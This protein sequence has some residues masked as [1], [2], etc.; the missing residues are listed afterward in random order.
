MTISRLTLPLLA[1]L[2]LALAACGINSVPRAEE[3]ARAKWAD[4]EAAYQRR[5]NLIP[6]LVE[7]VRGFAD[8]EREVLIGVA[9][10]RARASRVEISAED[11][12]D[13]EA[14]RQ[15][16]EAQGALGS[17]LG[18]L[19]VT[20][21]AYPELRSSELFANLQS[22]LEGTEN[23]IAIAI[24]DYNEAVRDYNT[25]LRT[26]PESIGASI[27]HGAEPMAL[28]EATTPGAEN[29]P[30]VDFSRDEGGNAQ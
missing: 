23:R 18:R 21:E 14:M 27:I 30:T 5:A 12:G 25:R 29:A 17:S 10:A 15:F 19:L 2:L 9:D 7:T 22:Q 8:Q 28:Y 6:N 4:V 26:F 16:A 11:V 24:R 20:M 3:T 13:P 1:P